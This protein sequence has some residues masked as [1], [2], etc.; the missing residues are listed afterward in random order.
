M[1]R[2][3]QLGRAVYATLGLAITILVITYGSM[4][5]WPRVAEYRRMR[6]LDRR[7]HDRNLPRAARV[8]AAEM[9][10]EFGPEA[11]PFLL[12]AARDADGLVREK[13]YSYLAGLDPLPEEAVSLCLAALKQEQ[14]Q[15]PRVRAA[16]AESLGAVAYIWRESRRDGRQLIIKSL[17]VAG[18]DRS[19]F[20]RHAVMRAMIHAN[21]VTV[22]ASPWLEDSNRYVRLAAAEAVINLA[23]RNKARVVPMLQAMIRQADPAR[24]ADL[25]RLFALLAYA[26]AAACR[27]LVPTFVSWLH[28]EDSAVRTRV[29]SWLLQLGPLARD[30]VPA[31]EALLDRAPPTDRPRVAFAIVVIDP[32]ACEPTAA[33]L[34]AMLRDAEIDP[35]ERI[36]ALGPLGVVLND[37]RVPARVRDDVHRVL[38]TI[39]DETG[40]HPEFARRVRR[41][42]AYQESVRARTAA[43]MARHVSAESGPT[44]PRLGQQ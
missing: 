3:P 25:G 10:A 31:L 20:V 17:V 12:A 34:L 32:A 4:I 44:A 22:D 7:W 1:V 23:P 38:V 29:I 37:P 11:G 6:D 43:A 39:P 30:A 35:R 28:H 9:L 21:A 33:K 14:E 24:T 19:P 16:A 42:L 18:H 36:Q 5:I 8:K 26:D 40:I 27:D 2:V 41:F 15:E 13:A